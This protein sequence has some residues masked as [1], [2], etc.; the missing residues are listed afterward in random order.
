MIAA[1]KTV[2]Q[3]FNTCLP[4]AFAYCAFCITHQRDVEGSHARCSAY[5][6]W[7]GHPSFSIKIVSQKLQVVLLLQ[8]KV[9]D[10]YDLGDRLLI[11]TT[12]RQSAFDRLLASVPYKVT[13]HPSFLQS[14]KICDLD[15]QFELNVQI[16]VARN[17]WFPNNV[18]Y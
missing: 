6:I 4:I 3:R 15:W 13:N 17:C 12:D 8:G 9:R 18:F 7:E 14:G 1:S 11:V 5:L 16:G 2:D 10:T